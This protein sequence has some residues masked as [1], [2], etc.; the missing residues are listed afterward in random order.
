[1]AVCKNAHIWL[2]RSA[3]EQYQ[4]TIREVAMLGQGVC[5]TRFY[6]KELSFLVGLVGSVSTGRTVDHALMCLLL[7][8]GVRFQCD[9]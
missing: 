3:G 4:Q 5:G 8:R 7:I 9:S 2:L 1:M 6:Q